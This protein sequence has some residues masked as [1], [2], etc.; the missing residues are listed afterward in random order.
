MSVSQLSS[1]ITKSSSSIELYQGESKDL[2]LEIVQSL[3]QPDGNEIEVPVDLTGAKI[4]F[5]VRKKIGDPEVKIHKD[6]TNA[7][8]VEILTPEENG[9]AIIHILTGDTNLLD[10]GSYVFDVWV[11]LSSGKK[12]PVIEPS[13]FLI[14][15]PVTKDC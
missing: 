7:L 13:E 3:E 14:K 10:P 12:V 11:I 6:S 5:T 1:N 9:L 2:N 15:E 8:D 4:C